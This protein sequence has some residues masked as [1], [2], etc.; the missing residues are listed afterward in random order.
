MATITPVNIGTAAVIPYA[1]ATIGGDSIATGGAKDIKLLVKN[2]SGSSINVTMTGVRPC[3][4]GS[5]H[6]VVTA[7]AAGAEKAIPVPA[8]CINP[9]TKA[10]AVTYSSATTVTVAAINP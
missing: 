5:T 2:G 1:S 3:D 8:Q 10:V 6:D 9:T 7:V 4:Q